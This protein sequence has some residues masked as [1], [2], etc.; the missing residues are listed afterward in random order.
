MTLVESLVAVALVGVAVAAILPA[1]V[2]L[3]DVNTRDEQ[4][5]EALAVAQ[6]VLEE[7]RRDNPADL[8]DSGASA[9]QTIAV[10]GRDYEVLVRYCSTAAY[11]AADRRHLLVEVSYGGR[12]IVA[13]ESVYTR[14]R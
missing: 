2:G 9:V 3:Q 4:R 13:I 7:L 12:E 1:F 11:C 10:D 6:Q 8:P 5:S 14:L